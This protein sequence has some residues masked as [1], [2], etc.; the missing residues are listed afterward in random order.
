[1]DLTISEVLCSYILWSKVRQLHWEDCN[2]QHHSCNYKRIRM[3]CCTSHLRNQPSGKLHKHMTKM[4]HVP[5]YQ[6]K[7]NRSWSMSCQWLHLS[8]TIKYWFICFSF[9]LSWSRSIGAR[10]VHS[11]YIR[12]YANRLA[13]VKIKSVFNSHQEDLRTVLNNHNSNLNPCGSFYQQIW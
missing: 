3:S 12:D 5:T 8:I 7:R 2:S 6:E 10:A 1:M 4:L 11:T 9:L 13:S